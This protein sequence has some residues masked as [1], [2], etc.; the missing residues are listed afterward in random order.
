MIRLGQVSDFVD[1]DIIENFGRC[2]DES[3][4]EGQIALPGAVTCFIV[5][6]DAAL[7][8]RPVTQVTPLHFSAAVYKFS[9]LV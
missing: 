4:I 8:N 7:L 2:N 1:D 6:E 3:P 5:D 9:R